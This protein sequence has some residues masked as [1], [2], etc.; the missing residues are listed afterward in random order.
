M[1][2]EAVYVPRGAQAQQ[3]TEE[4]GRHDAILSTT[5]GPNLK[6]SGCCKTKK[7]S[8]PDELVSQ[9]GCRTKVGQSCEPRCV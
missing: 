6:S 7:G 3:V 5:D 9:V 4:S 1:S 8:G 2:R